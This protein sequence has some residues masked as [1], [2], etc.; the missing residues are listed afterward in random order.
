MINTSAAL[1]GR[2]RRPSGVEGHLKS[3]STIE[4]MGCGRPI[5]AEL[6]AD[7]ADGKTMQ[8][9]IGKLV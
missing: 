8:L 5:R 3:P 4:I 7:T 9:Q 1:G 6:I 2:A